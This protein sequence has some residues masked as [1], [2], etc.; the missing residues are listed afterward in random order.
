MI[1]QI[2]KKLYFSEVTI[3]GTHI[4]REMPSY[5]VLLTYKGVIINYAN[6]GGNC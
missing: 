1:R 4:N 3:V 5:W 2:L 6:Y